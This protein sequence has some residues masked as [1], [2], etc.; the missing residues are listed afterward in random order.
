MRLVRV[1]RALRAV[2]VPAVVAALVAFPLGVLA[3]HSFTD[4]P[5]GHPFHADIAALKDSG[6]SP[7]GCGGGNF[8]PD[9][10]VTRGQMAAFLNR[11]GALGPGKTPVANAS[12]VDGL[13]ANAINRMAYGQVLSDTYIDID[14]QRDL[15]T[16]TLDVPVQSLVRVSFAGYA[17]AQGATGCPCVLQGRIQMDSSTSILVTDQNLAGDA[18]AI[19]GSYDREGV[20]GSYVFT[21]PAGSHTFT[22][23]MER[24][25]GATTA[26]IGMSR[27]NAQAEAV[28]FTG[29]GTPA[30]P[31]GPQ[32]PQQL[33]DSAK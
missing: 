32:K 6:V 26:L 13:D 25:T 29:T 9:D 22:I 10:F 8:C 27:I 1:A 33:P 31:L 12:K 28:P 7:T 16:L 19:V 11:V 21:A 4:V 18:G 23:S 5:T 2:I 24:Q 14:G 20:A 3:S 17:I 30:A 15:V